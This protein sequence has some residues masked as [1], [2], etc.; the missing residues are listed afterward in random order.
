MASLSLILTVAWIAIVAGLRSAIQLRQTGHIGLYRGDRTGSAQWWSRR[1]STLGVVLAVGAPLAEM[2]GLEPVWLLDQAAIRAVGVGLFVLGVVATVVCQLVMGESWRAD[3]DPDARTPLVT[4]G[5]YQ[6]VRNPILTA[7]AM[8]TIGLA[9][10][11]P[12]VVAL[13]MLFLVGAAM[14]IQVRL[15][16]E[17]YLLRVHGEAYRRYAARTGRFLPRLGRP[18]A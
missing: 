1:I 15:V 14:Q 13:G 3:V 9:L 6:W 2:A 7:T 5:P 11:V 8:T 12:N 17:P 18:E 10:M 4:G 16:E